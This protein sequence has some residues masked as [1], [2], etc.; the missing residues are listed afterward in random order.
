MIRSSR[1]TLLAALVASIL[2]ATRSPSLV[3]QTGGAGTGGAARL[4]QEQKLA[5]NWR[6]V[7][8]IGA[9]PDDED[10][11]L[12]TI[13][14]RGQGIETAY[15]S[16]TR[17]DGGQNLIGSELGEALGVLRTEELASARRIDGGRQFFTRA[18]DFGFSKTAEETLRFWNGD[19]VLKDM[20]RIIR[21]FKP[22]VI[23]SVF[24]G[25]PADG[26][27]NHQASG[28]LSLEAYHAAGDSTRFPELQREGLQAWQ[29][30][31]FYRAA[32]GGGNATLTFNGGVI[33]PAT[34]LS[35]RQLAVRS[36]SQHRSQNQ[37]NL[38]ELGP[39]SSGV[40]LVERI[41][42]IDGRD[43]SLFAGIA[44]E[45]VD[46]LDHHTAEVRLIEHGIVLDAT[47]EDDEVTPGEALPVT[48]KTWNTGRD[49]VFMLFAM[50]GHA[51]FTSRGDRCPQQGERA[52]APGEL[53]TCDYATTVTDHAEPTAPYY[54]RYARIGSLYQWA[55]A[56]ARILGD[57]SEPPLEASFRFSFQRGG[58]PRNGMTVTR[59]VQARFRDPVLGEVRKPVMIVQPITVSLEPS[60]MLWP[61]GTR[62]RPFK[63]ELE[64]LGRDSSDATVSLMVPAGWKTT[65]PQPVH[66]TREGERTVVTFTVTAPINVRAGAVEI[67]AHAVSETDTFNTGLYRIRYPHIRDR[68]LVTAAQANVV[69]A[70]VKFPELATIG[71]VR[72]GGDLVPE[73]MTDA[74]LSVKLLTGDA[75]ER[76]PLDQF[77]VIVIGPRAYEAD[78]SL[79]RAHPRLMRWLDAGGTLVIQYQQ[80]PYVR[81]GFPPKPLTLVAPTQSRVT[82][83]TAAVTF[84]AP[85]HQVVRWP[86]VITSK[87]FDGWIQDRGLDFPP[88]YD[89][90]WIPI[91]S[92]HDPGEKAL[93]GALLVAKVGRG[94]AVYTGL[95]FNRQLPATVPGAWR[96]WANIL[97]AGQA[98]APSV[99]R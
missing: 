42:S 45:V 30:S 88:T 75:L 49:T 8:M 58:I 19:S 6:R 31:K 17:G 52:V 9:H 40:R 95:A 86:N 82:D 26:H 85:T 92:M 29:P 81:G 47:T 84:L 65:S 10:T 43:D 41:P 34:G 22:Q 79:V 12:L 21:R 91:F 71:Y 63:V 44:P 15:L 48:L 59:E 37:G 16:L 73:A 13:L 66:F 72:G 4:A 89:P 67:A 2:V 23:V 5:G 64:H 33:D 74:G 69:V 77:K 24:Q 93:D 11:E 50:V 56:N 3:A 94:T 99:K 18:F 38:E 60:Q 87:D 80:T 25:T 90:A 62:V 51:G 46:G 61:L 27:G 98:P 70:D 83:E 54:L 20:V 68:N 36:R 14:A 39:S 1:T 35:L 96:L 7:L 78:E 53:F 32:R 55:G 28:I 97:G 76:G 57:P